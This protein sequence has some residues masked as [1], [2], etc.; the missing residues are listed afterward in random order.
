MSQAESKTAKNLNRVGG[1][2]GSASI[3]EEIE[4]QLNIWRE[5]DLE[6]KRAD[7]PQGTALRAS[8]LRFLQSVQDDFGVILF[9]IQEP[10]CRWN[11]LGR[12]PCP[13]YD[14]GDSMLAIA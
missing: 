11:L 7:C 9:Q 14:S 1:K 2:V 12:I 10:I 4:N 3:L 8:V 5:G 13:I 6:K